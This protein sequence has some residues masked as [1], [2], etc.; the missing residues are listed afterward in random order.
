[1]PKEEEY[2]REAREE[3]RPQQLGTRGRR[4]DDS[5]MHNEGSRPR[6]WGGDNILSH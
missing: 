1:M 5:S 3:R 6:D 4:D 2:R